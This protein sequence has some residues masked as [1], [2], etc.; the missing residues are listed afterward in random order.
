[1]K[2]ESKDALLQLALLRDTVTEVLPYL[3]QMGDGYAAFG[4]RLRTWMSGGVRPVRSAHWITAI[5]NPNE[6]KSYYRTAEQILRECPQFQHMLHKLESDRR[7]LIEQ[8]APLRAVGMLLPADD[9]PTR[10]VIWLQG[11]PPLGDKF[12]PIEEVD[13]WTW[14]PITLA[15]NN[16]DECVAW[17]EGTDDWALVYSPT[18]P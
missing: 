17:S 18:L 15:H 12:V 16:N 7:V 5:Q 6:N 9:L 4:D 8:M 13:G 14:Y 10:S 1:V 11:G 3:N 2:A